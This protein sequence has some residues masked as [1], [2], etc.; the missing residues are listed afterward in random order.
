MC[1][2]AWRQVNQLPEL[3][4]LQLS[5]PLRLLE[6]GTHL[7]L[8]SLVETF[9]SLWLLAGERLQLRIS[10]PLLPLLLQLLQQWLQLLSLQQHWKAEERPW[11]SPG[12]W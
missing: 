9:V 5:L 10:L 4:F 1:P 2:P 12:C 7:A 6:V 3:L 8:T 11:H